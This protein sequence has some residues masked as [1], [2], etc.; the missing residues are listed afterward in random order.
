MSQ[1]Q[2]RLDLYD[3]SWYN[4]G[5]SK[6]SR[7][8]WYFINAIIFNSALFPISS[9]KVLML[10]VFGAKIGKGVVIKPSVNIK[11]PWKLEIDDFSWIGEEVWIDNL[12]K[13]Q[14]GKSCCV[15]QGA[16]LL[17]GNHNYSS[18]KFDLMIGE[19]HL[20]NGAW[21]GANS[22]VCPGTV[23]KN[24]AVLSAGSLAKGILEPY[25]VYQGN[26]AVKIKDRTISDL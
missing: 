3:N 9:F 20:E 10:R 8:I 5:G 24:H 2:T 19:I 21:I 6:L 16:L 13:V 1:Q 14:V 25:S 11:Y 18:S 7:L 4:P 26:P 22:I 12:A 17:C 15:S 23:V